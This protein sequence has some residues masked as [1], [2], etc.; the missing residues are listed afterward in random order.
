M[1]VEMLRHKQEENRHLT[2]TRGQ[3]G[4]GMGLG[5]IGGEDG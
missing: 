3:Y 1:C 2:A 5:W 4:E